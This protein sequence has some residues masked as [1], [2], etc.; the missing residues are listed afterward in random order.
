MIPS[1]LKSVLLTLDYYKV[2][3]AIVV[4]TL[5]ILWGVAYRITTHETP[6]PN[7]VLAIG[8][9]IS[10]LQ[11][12]KY[13]E[14]AKQRELKRQLEASYMW[15]VQ[16]D[17]NINAKRDQLMELVNPSDSNLSVEFNAHVWE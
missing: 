14:L 16:I 3:I 11:S 10:T 6:K 9:E 5:T 13:V 7:E 15:V 8:N 1:Q 17:N 2:R 12:K 4:I